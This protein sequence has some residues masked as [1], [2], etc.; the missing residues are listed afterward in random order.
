VRMQKI[1]GSCQHEKID[2][3]FYFTVQLRRGR[4]FA[5]TPDG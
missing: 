3:T 1:P 2:G 4:S 5:D